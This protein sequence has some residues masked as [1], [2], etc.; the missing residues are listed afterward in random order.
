MKDFL[1]GGISCWMQE[2]SK[3]AG[4]FRIFEKFSEQIEILGAIF[5]KKFNFFEKVCSLPKNIKSN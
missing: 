1:L 3:I 4:S 2:V 5:L